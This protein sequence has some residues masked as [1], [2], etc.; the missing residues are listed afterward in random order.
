[1]DESAMETTF[2]ELSV[3]GKAV[4]VEAIPIHDRLIVV[5]GRWLKTATV[6]GEAWLDGEAVSDPPLFIRAL[7]ES[8]L[9]PDLFSF[10]QTLHERQPK[11]EYP[12]EWDNVA[13]IPLTTYDAWW[14][15]QI[16]RK[17]RQEVNRAERMGVAVRQVEFNDDL[18]RGISGVYNE[19]PIRQGRP[20]WHY[21]KDLEAV[22]RENST[23]LDRSEFAAAYC[24]DEMVGFIKL[25][26]GNR[27]ASFMQILSKTSHNDKRPLNALIAKAVEMAAKKGCAYLVYGQYTYD[28]KK[29]SSIVEFKRRS[30]FEEVLFPRYFVPLTA[31][32]RIALKFR[33]HLGYRRLLPE[34]LVKIL[35]SLRAR[36]LASPLSPWRPA[37]S[38]GRSAPPRSAAGGQA[39]ANSVDKSL[40]RDTD[41]SA[42]GD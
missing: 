24:G 37:R 9:R 20:F 28:N 40:S 15:R 7:K 11:Y 13:A 6:K 16:S 17:T 39:S 1:M 4:R 22:K 29:D 10:A 21:G 5:T 30:G 26:Y 33:L 38:P 19:T 18:V 42:E 36:I 31:K 3:K 25:V 23:Y 35:L 41:G 34:K 32:G 12:V 8:R 2:T 14:E 27:I